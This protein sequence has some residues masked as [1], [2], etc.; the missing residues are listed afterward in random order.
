MKN[1][2]IVA[3]IITEVLGSPK[4]YVEKVL[5]DILAKFEKE[6]DVKVIDKVVYDAEQQKN[7]LWSAFAEI[8]FEV[9]DIKKLMYVCFDYTPSTIEILE[10]AGLTIDSND[11]MEFLNDI[12]SK[13]HQYAMVIKNFQANTIVMQR[14]M[15][16]LKQK[17]AEIEAKSKK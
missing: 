14:E 1:P 5:Q 12:L 17:L 4:D 16:A 11:I 13:I 2:K 3:R 6:K 15:Q 10:P 8:E 7:K 9:P